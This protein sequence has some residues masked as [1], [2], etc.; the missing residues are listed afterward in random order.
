MRLFL[1]LS[2]L[3]PCFSSLRAEELFD[4][5]AI[6]DVESL[7]IEVVQDWKQAPKDPAVRQKLIEVTVCE[8]WPGQKVRLP[9]TLNAPAGRG[10]CRN[11]IVANQGLAAKPALPVGGQL[12]LLK[13]QGV[14]VVLI[15]MG[16]IDAMEPKGQLHL[17]MRKQLLETKDVRYTPAWI[18]G[19][20]QMRGLTAAMSEPAVFRPEKVLTTGG[21]KRGVASAMAGIFD[22]RFTAI[23]PVVAPMLGNPGTPVLV[24]GTE[25]EELTEIDDEFYE[26]ISPEA[27]KALK[28]R[29]VRR[30]TQ[31]VGLADAEAA[32]WTREEMEEMADKVWDPCRIVS[33]LP[34]LERRG[35]EIFYN[36]GTNDSVSPALPELGTLLPDFPICIIPGGQHG[37]PQTAGFSKQV[38]K[39]KE[40]QDNLVSFARHH[41]FSERGMPEAPVINFG[42]GDDGIE[43][44]VTFSDDTDP[45]KNEM[46]WCYDRSKVYTL[47]FEFDEWESAVLVKNED[48]TYSVTIPIEEG[49]DTI[50][51]LSLHTDT[52]NE[53]PITF[54][55]P[56]R[57]VSV[58]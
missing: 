25:P 34:V 13:E 49:A 28:E 52:E 43:V 27:K 54:S 10:P 53:L 4:L 36:V 38:P 57:R 2:L 42:T 44:T 19:M 5:E 24:V 8:W 3:L 22:D 46:W 14:G 41:F 6:R 37:G 16:T 56:Y 11:V 30:A 48:G 29:A 7:E 9:V 58:K 32:G 18:W 20:S 51:F 17:G 33:Y 15:G 12:E 31:R 55:S 39:Q 26:T 40:I 21:S 45:E 50:D 23:L 35:L 1:I 47:P